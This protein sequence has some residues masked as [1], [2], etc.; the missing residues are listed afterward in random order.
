MRTMS[1]FILSLLFVFACQADTKNKTEV[2]PEK[3]YRIVYEARSND[4]YQAQ[5]EL[6]KKEIDKDPKS[7]EAWY[8]YYN[9]NRYANFEDIEKK[10]KKVRLEKIIEDMGQAIP[11][12]YTFYLLKYWDSY[13]MDDMSLVKKAYEINPN[14][15]D[16]YYPFLSHAQIHNNQETVEEFCNKL[17]ECKDI[18]PWLYNYNYNVLMSV[19]PNSILFTNG[20]NDTY[21]A[22]ILQNVKD[23]RKDVTILNVSLCRIAAYQENNLAKKGI[24]VDAKENIKKALSA[25][26][27]KSKTFKTDVLVNELMKA[28]TKQQP[29]IPIY[30]AL[31]VYDKF[32]AD[33]KDNLY[34][35]GLAYKYSPNRIDNLA[36]I[37]KNFEKNLRLDYLTNDWYNEDQ[38]GINM[39]HNMN[40]N[41]VVPMIMLAKHYKDSGQSENTEQWKKLAV[42]LANNAGNKK[43][44]EEIKKKGL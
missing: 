32:I 16:T 19:A 1:S 25:E 13:H 28:I 23:I 21:P 42:E 43:I 33:L 30:F 36:L 29:D 7:E 6:W 44:L 39:N 18:S 15:P 26:E 34:I 41:Y 22:W 17:Y 14:R 9:A 31:T 24:E 27:G 35:V 4:W 20:D 12:T 5:S 37:K 2:K 10:N 3:V 8:N 40:L 11:G 38:L